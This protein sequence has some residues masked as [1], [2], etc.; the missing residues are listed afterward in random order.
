MAE[1]A[2]G[3]GQGKLLVRN[4]LYNGDNLAVLR[5]GEIPPGS[6][7]LVY[8]DP[9]FKSGQ[10][11]NQIFRGPSGRK[12]AAQRQA[13]KDTWE[14]GPEAMNAFHD[15]LDTAPIDVRIALQSLRS[16]VGETSLLAYLSMMAPRLVELER[17]LVDGG[18]LYL[19]CDPTASHYLKVLLDAVFGPN[20]F[21]NEVIWSYRRWPSPSNHY[22][23]MHDCLL[24]YAKGKKGPKTFNV[25]YEPTSDSYQKRFG[26]KTQ[27]LDPETKSRKITSEEESKGMPLRDVWSI[28]IIAGFSKERTGWPTQKP[29]RLLER[30]ISVSSN[31]GDVV[32][33][34][35][36]GCGTAVDVAEKLKRRW[37][38]IDIARHATDVIEDRLQKTHGPGVKATYEFIPKPVTAEDARKL[39][40]APFL[41]QWWAL[42]KV[43]AQPAPKRKGPDKGVD[44]RLYFREHVGADAIDAK[45]VV[46]SVKAG[47]TGPHHVRELRGV[48]EREGAAIGVLITLRKPT[49]AMLSEAAESEPYYSST[50]DRRYQRLQVITVEDLMTPAPID[51]P[52]KLPPAPTVQES[53]PKF[54]PLRHVHVRS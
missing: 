10:K 27:R 49:K 48:V 36:C 51:Y 32:M 44:G 7:D 5:E 54:E 9:P 16:I 18:S 22:Q 40:D 12:S 41:F 47:Q 17:V 30:I 1:R 6:V 24:F 31:E 42:E 43:G 45:Q 19:H 20:G 2:R 29:A 50:W 3:R 4:R 23:R 15:T 38:G 34:P 52:A 26:G 28:S 25:E 37:I 14:W 33:D 39:K 35:F 11:Y 13:F 21:Q 8:L 53:V 46:I